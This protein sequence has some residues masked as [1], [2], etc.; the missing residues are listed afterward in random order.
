MPGAI[1]RSNAPNIAHA[2]F[3]CAIAG[4]R[5][6]CIDRTI[7]QNERKIVKREMRKK[8]EK[9]RERNYSAQ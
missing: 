1:V 9:D 2:H 3:M 4:W 8:K 7:A 5:R 6:T